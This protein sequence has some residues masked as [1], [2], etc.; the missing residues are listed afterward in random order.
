MVGNKE[1]VW[2]FLDSTLNENTL[3]NWK[4]GLKHPD[5]LRGIIILDYDCDNI[6]SEY[7]FL[8]NELS[9]GNASYTF[10]KREKP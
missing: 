4:Y 2:L 5:L 1:F 3:N 6:T 9:K 7:K 10:P 8:K